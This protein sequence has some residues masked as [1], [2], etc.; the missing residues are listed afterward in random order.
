NPLAAGLQESRMAEPALMVIFGA[1]GDLSK[2]KLLPSIYNLARQ[3]LLPPGFAVVGAAMDDLSEEAFR[4]RAKDSVTQFSRTQPVDQ[5]VL[6]AFLA[7]LFYVP[8]KFDD[9]E[10][11]KRLKSRLD[12][13]ENQ[14]HTGG[15]VVFYCAVPPPVYPQL[16]SQ[17]GAC[18]LAREERGYRRIIVE[19]PFGSDLKSARELNVQLQKVFRE[20][21]VYR[22]DHYLGKETVQNIMVFRF[23]NAIF[24]PVWNCNFVDSVQI[25][26]AEELGVEG[27]GGYY[28]QAGALRDIVQNH[29]LQLVTLT[30]MEPPV[31][32]DA[33][34]VRD[35]KV[36]VLRAVRPLAVDEMPTH[37]VRGQYTGGFVLGQKVPGYREEQSV[38]PDSETETFA[39]IKFQVDNWR[40]A[41]VPFYVRSGKRMPKRVTEIRVQFKR[42][43]HLTFGREQMRET[44]P[45]ALILRIQPE[46]GI[47][48]KFSAKVPS[49]GVR[50]RTVNMDFLYLSSFVAD[51]PDAYERLLVDCMLGDPTLFTRSDEVEHAWRFVDAIEESWRRGKPPLEQYKAGTWGPKGS[52][53]LLE[54]DARRWAVP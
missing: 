46:D 39:A 10:A 53:R 13:L 17:L 22:I 8:V 23:A 41:D 30:A 3:R 37:T 11:F 43:P 26:V 15:N 33:T 16:V 2:R 34:S 5:E 20:D 27:R 32:F 50:L 38:K 42:P 45:N 44:L 21:N 12:E 25:T 49:G 31:A 6:K 35:E 18:G 52:D 19:K 29:A 1:T 47:S 36:K 14:R 51:A 54:A 4:D 7:N 40:W 9:A 28:D 48:L 24:E